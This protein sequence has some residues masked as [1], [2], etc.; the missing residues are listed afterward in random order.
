[1][2]TSE[3]GVDEEDD[4]LELRSLHM[5]TL[6]RRSTGA[7]GIVI[8]VLAVVVVLSVGSCLWLWDSNRRK[9]KRLAEEQTA[10]TLDAALDNVEDRYTGFQGRGNHPSNQPI[11]MSGPW[12]EEMEP[13]PA[14][15]PT[16]GIR[17]FY[18]GVASARPAVQLPTQTQQATD[19][20]ARG[21]YEEGGQAT[22]TVQKARYA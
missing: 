3:N 8:I 5:H 4:H 13:K 11:K 21:F 2:F 12:P 1:M 18:E 15:E 9:K 10:A 14:A 19:G 16:G 22:P 7:A 20:G 17:G 6:S